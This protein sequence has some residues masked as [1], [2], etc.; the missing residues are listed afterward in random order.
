MTAEVHSRKRGRPVNPNSE[1][2]LA[3]AR[4]KQR[5]EQRGMYTAAPANEEQRASGRKRGRPVDPQTALR[6]KARLRAKY[7]AEIAAAGPAGIQGPPSTPAAMQEYR[8]CCSA[9]V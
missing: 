4:Q 6:R 7:D 9:L 8:A 3:L 1:R 5:D 2:Q